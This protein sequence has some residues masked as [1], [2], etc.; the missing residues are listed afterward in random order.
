[1]YTNRGAKIRTTKLVLLI[2][3][4]SFQGVLIRGVSFQDVLI[5]E[6]SLSSFQGVL[7]KEVPL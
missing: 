7:I 3:V 5:E 1:M 4:S 2:K 6:A